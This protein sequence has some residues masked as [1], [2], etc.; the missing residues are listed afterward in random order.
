MHHLRIAV[1]ALRRR[2]GLTALNVAGLAVGLA[3]ALLITL[4]VRDETGVD[5]GLPGGDRVFRLVG[6]NH[7]SAVGWPYGRIIAAEYPEVEH[8]T[9]VRTSPTFVLTHGGERLY[10]RTLNADGA[11]FEVFPFP[12][13][14]GTPATA[15]D[16]PYSVV[17][18]DSLARALYGD[19]G[20]LGRALV[21][22]DSLTFTVT[23][24]V[25]V[26]R[27]S[28]VRA[29]AFTSFSTL[30]ARDPEW[31]AS[32][33]AEGWLNLNVVNYVRLRPGTDPAAFAAKIHDLP[34]E[35]AGEP[36]RALGTDFRLGL[37]P[38]GDVYFS[39]LGNPLGRSGARSTVLLLS[40]IGVFLLLLAAVNFVNLA[41]ARSVERAKEVGVRKAVGSGRG[42]LVRQF[43][44]ESALMAVGAGLL[45]AGLAYA[46]LP[47]F[48]RLTARAFTPAD[49]FSLPSVLALAA[50]TLGVGLLAGAYPALVLSGF[51]PMEVL[52]GRFTA[53]GRGARLRQGLVVFQFAVTCVLLVG[54]LVVF[55]Q[56]GYMRGQ[57]PGFNEEQVLLLD[58]R[59]APR[60][61][62]AARADAF[63]QAL[64][65]GPAV[66]RVTSAFGFPG[67]GG[68]QGQV[69]FPEGF[70]DGESIS[71]EYV[72]VEAGYVRT[73]GLD[74]VAGRDFDPALA[75]DAETAVVIN[76]TAARLAGWTPAEAVGRAFTSPG[77]GKPDG[78]VVGVVRDF[79]Q[80]GLQ[81]PIGPIMLGLGGPM[82]PTVAFRLRGADAAAVIAHARRTWEAFF[83]GSPVEFHFL[84]EVF[85]RQ[86]AEEARLARVFATFTGLAV[87]VAVLGLVGLAAFA[88]QQRTKEIGVRKVLGASVPAIVALLSRD[89]LKLVGLAF[90]LAAPLAYWAMS[91][92]LEGF[93]YRVELGPGLFVAAGALAFAAAL[94]ATSVHALRAATA[95]PVKALR[96][97]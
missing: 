54:T 14:E 42:A 90:L 24:V 64:A 21:L 76:E 30:G 10:E 47:W 96:S 38:L 27:R 44:A 95:D 78:V 66:E 19:A 79:H 33:F 35:R 93:A 82:E 51:R 74:V 8:V 86:Y 97:E 92:W 77:S 1:R 5:R 55:R 17:L 18:S 91:R 20:A 22:D 41:T 53:G 69:S 45:A 13:V 32:E 56:L 50:L 26:P 68:W 29:A 88:A 62:L 94:A 16:A 6:E 89:F 75:T 84:D 4:F 46:A 3:A 57:S 70:P 39:P 15:L 12:F 58:A 34:M 49:L 52:R 43:L 73:L 65:A 11:F 40:A 72:P 23:G 67:Q 31:I 83:P 60:N 63:R 81:Q 87:L 59:R 25:R 37:E 36:L 9:Y 61:E 28:H 7:S 71:L 80:H 85:A 48:D 2:K